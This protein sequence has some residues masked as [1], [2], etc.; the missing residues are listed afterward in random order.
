MIQYLSNLDNKRILILCAILLI[1]AFFLNL[2]L[3]V[4]IEDESL[5]ALVALE[6]MYSDNY[7]APTLNGSYYYY[8]PPLYNWILTI[9]YRVFGPGELASRIPT[10]IFTLGLS[11]IIYSFNKKYLEKQIALFTALAFL[12]CGRILFWDSFLGLIDIFYSLV[13][14]TMMM[15]I[16]HFGKKE[17]WTHLYLSIYLLTAT[18][19]MLKGFPSFLFLGFTLLAF[20]VVFK[21][22]KHLIRPIHFISI[23]LM[24]GLIGLYYWLYSFYHN[25][26]ENF[27]PLLDQSTRRT[28][29]RYDWMAMFKHILTYPF[30]NLYHFLPWSLFGILLIRKDIL[31]VLKSNDFVWFSSLTFL[32]NIL[33]YWISPEVYAR[34]VLMLAPLVFSIQFF[35]YQRNDDSWRIKALSLL[36]KAT[37]LCLPILCLYLLFNPGVEHVSYGLT[38]VVAVFIGLALLA[39]TYFINPKQRVLILVA[40]CLLIRIAFNGVIHTDRHQRDFAQTAKLE[41]IRIGEKYKGKNIEL[42]KSG[43]I[44][45]TSS[46]YIARTRGEITYRKQKDFE[47][48]NFYF[49]DTVRWSF[50]EW[51]HELVDSFQVRENK[52]M[53]YV[54]QKTE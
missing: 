30:E 13:I 41:A 31:T 21:K 37:V 14:Y 49:L 29:V 9:F 15:S 5:R 24:F 44:D 10:V 11:W 25:P 23:T 46:F 19:Y 22:W 4:F 51:K 42:Y 45:Y 48:D 36:M 28:V 38:L 16:Y 20:C 26:I 6:M 1:P 52:N 33:V 43:K 27:E 50:P 54:I 47:K 18:G 3:R 7:I 34:Y 8:K 2:D 35:L 40:M 32:S 53:I 39:I 17:K 12:T